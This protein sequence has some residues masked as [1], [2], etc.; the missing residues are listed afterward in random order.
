MSPWLSVDRALIDRACLGH[1]LHPRR[2]SRPSF[3]STNRA[4]AQGEP[5]PSEC[6]CWAN[7]ISAQ[8]MFFFVERFTIY[9]EVWQFYRKDPSLHAYNYS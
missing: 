3:S 1:V 7:W 8:L 6:P 2:P 9:P 4:L 5:P